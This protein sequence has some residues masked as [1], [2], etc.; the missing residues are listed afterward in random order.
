MTT[1]EEILKAFNAQWYNTIVK[2]L[3]VGQKF[4]LTQG[5]TSLGQTSASVWNIFDATTP[6]SIDHFYDPDQH[7]VFSQKYGAVINNLIPQNEGDLL[8]LLGDDYTDWQA[9]MADEKHYPNPIPTLPSGE[10]DMDKLLPPM[11]QRWGMTRGLEP[12]TINAGVT[13]IKQKDIITVAIA[14]WVAAAGNYA[15]NKTLANV[16]SDIEGGEKKTGDFDSKTASKDI[17]H[18]WANAEVSGSYRFFSG[19]VSGSWDKF[20]SDINE[21]GINIQIEF[22]KM[23]TVA[24]G[25]L[26]KANTLDPDL[27]R[28]LPW[29]NSAAFKIA[30]ENNNNKVWKPREP[31]WETVFGNGGSMLFVP[32]A[33]IVVDGINTTMTSK[34]SVEKSEQQSIKAAFEAGFWPFF[35][36][37]GEGGWEH[38]VKFND[39]GSFEVKSSSK[40]GNPVVIGVLVDTIDE[41]LE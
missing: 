12:S 30:K 38:D 6:K 16:K 22:T 26:A 36:A 27:K 23:A 11:F 28:Y 25:P 1:A 41:I 8:K 33:M 34:A 18:S 21:K 35:Q 14:M 31:S 5:S 24:C 29:W 20:T 32:T 9:Y 10:I 37:K 39:D 40:V 13:L 17:S 19:K 3:G 15:Y 7:N 4:Q 2:V